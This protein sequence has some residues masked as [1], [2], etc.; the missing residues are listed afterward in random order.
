MSDCLQS[1]MHNPC[2]H[3][4]RLYEVAG[5]DFT[6]ELCGICL[7]PKASAEPETSKRTDSEKA[8]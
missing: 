2:P 1:N 8:I 6:A 7:T 4:W 3:S 5:T